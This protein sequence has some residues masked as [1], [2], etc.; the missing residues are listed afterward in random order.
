MSVF[1]A[2]LIRLLGKAHFEKKKTYAVN[3]EKQ[4]LFKGIVR[5]TQTLYHMLLSQVELVMTWCP[6]HC[7][8]YMSMVLHAN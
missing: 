3:A 1:C 5:T 8:L 6:C 7:M 2:R 4:R